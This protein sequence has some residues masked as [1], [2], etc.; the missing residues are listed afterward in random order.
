MMQRIIFIVGCLFIVSCGGS[1]DGGGEAILNRPVLLE[2][3]NQF[4]CL[5]HENINFQWTSVDNANEYQI[6]VSNTSNFSS[7]S[8][9]LSGL[10]N[11]STLLSL[12]QGINYY[13]RV[14]AFSGDVESQYSNSFQF[15]TQGEA[16]T[17]RLPQTPIVISPESNESISAAQVNLAWFSTDADVSDALVFDVYFGADNTDLALVS[18]DQGAKTYHVKN[19][20]VGQIYYWRIA[21]KDNEGGVA[22]SPIWSFNVTN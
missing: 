18:Q 10:V 7:I 21:A 15:Y 5:D 11:N 9:R 12:N 6:E 4:I 2:P 22:I 20:V 1:D 14:K 19:L 3:T 16:D 8:K 17:N 13:W